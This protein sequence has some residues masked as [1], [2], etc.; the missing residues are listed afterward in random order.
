MF[1]MLPWGI[2]FRIR[3]IFSCM[4]DVCDMRGINF[5]VI[6]FLNFILKVSWIFCNLHVI[7]IT[8]IFN[9]ILHQLHIT[10]FLRFYASISCLVLLFSISFFFFYSHYFCLIF[11]S[12]CFALFRENGCVNVNTSVSKLLMWLFNAVMKLFHLMY[13]YLLIDID[14]KVLS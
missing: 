11:Y 1:F 3:C 10:F 7:K 13:M 14:L 9:Y 4:I 2:R 5:V 12:L 8:G 6:S